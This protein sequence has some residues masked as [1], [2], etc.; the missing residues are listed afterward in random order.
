MYSAGVVA[1]LGVAFGTHAACS[2]VIGQWFI[3]KREKVSGIVFSGAGFG[4]AFWVF[5]AGQMF[6]ITNYKNSYRVLA[7][8]C[9]IIGLFAVFVLIRTPES[10]GQKPYE[11]PKTEIL[12]ETSDVQTAESPSVTKSQ[13]LKSPSF[14]I[15]AAAIFLTAMSGCTYL[16]FSPTWWSMH[17]MSSTMAANWTAIYLVLAGLAV[18]VVGSIF[19]K[20]GPSL[21]TVYVIVTFS[22]SL[23]FLI[24]Y[25]MT[26]GT[27]IMFGTVVFGALGYPIMASIPGLITQSVFGQKHFAVISATM[28]TAVYAGQALSAP[29]MSFFLEAFG[30]MESAWIFTF[31][32]SLIGM[33]L[34]LISIRISPVRSKS[35]SVS[36]YN[37]VGVENQGE[38]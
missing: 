10:M 11:L 3:D 17:G 4:A 31:I 21:F 28:M 29:V 9:I 13:A 14:W 37:N 16:S 19:K 27:L 12:K 30:S 35:K 34:I 33:V 15:L 36:Q 23:V 18:M 6:S 26:P 7:V 24:I 1:A 22:I 32:V 25:G 38:M 20:L 5:L 8:L 2:V